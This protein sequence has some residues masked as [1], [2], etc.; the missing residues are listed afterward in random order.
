MVP[1]PS[2]TDAFTGNGTTG[3]LAVMGN[4]QDGYRCVVFAVSLQTLVTV[5]DFGTLFRTGADVAWLKKRSRQIVVFFQHAGGAENRGQRTEVSRQNKECD[6]EID[7][8]RFH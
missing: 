7:P 6:C 2:R 5:L 4:S 3:L 1:I 8:H